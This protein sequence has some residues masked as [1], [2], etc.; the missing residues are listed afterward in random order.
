MKKNMGN[1]DR[2]LRLVVAA[3]VIVLFVQHIIAGTLGIILIVIAGVF[4]LT[5]FIGFCPV[6]VALGINTCKGKAK[7]D[8]SVS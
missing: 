6:Y 1:L 4:V 3:V 5:S 2:V 7:A 8:H